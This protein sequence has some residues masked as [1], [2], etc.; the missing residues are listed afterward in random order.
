MSI[1]WLANLTSLLNVDTPDTFNWLVS[2]VAST[3]ILL[4]NVDIPVNVDAADTVM[5]SKIAWPSTSIV[6]LTVWLPVNARTVPLNVKLALSSNSPPVPAITIR[7]SVRSSTLNVF[8]WPPPLIST[9]PVN[10]ERPP[11]L[12]L[13]LTVRSLKVKSSPGVGAPVL[14]IYL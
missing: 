2:V 5:S 1:F 6:P 11:T 9:S 13:R 12:K 14:P 10:V 3:K 7:L 4:L 8:A